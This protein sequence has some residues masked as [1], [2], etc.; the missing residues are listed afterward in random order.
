MKRIKMFATCTAAA[1]MITGCAAS[2]TQ[3]TVIDRIADADTEVSSENETGEDT[4]SYE[5]DEAIELSD[6]SGNVNITEGG[7]YL[8][9]GSSEDCSVRIDAGEDESVT[10]IL[11]GV[12][13]VSSSSAAI[14]AQSAGDV[15]IILADDCVLMNEEGFDDSEYEEIDA[16][17]CSETDMTISG[18]GELKITSGAGKGIAVNDSLVISGG[19]LDIDASDDGINVNEDFLMTGGSLTV[20]AGDDGIHADANLTVEDGNITINGAEGLEATYVLINGGKITITAADDGINAAQKNDETDVKVEINGGD[21]TIV[22]GEGDTDGIDSN[23]D[24]IINGGRIDITG[25]SACDYDGKA[26]LNG[27]TL[28]ING[29]ET[30]AIPNQFMGGGFG[31]EGVFGGGTVP[32][33]GHAPG[34]GFNG[35]EDFAPGNGQA[36]GEP[37]A[38][39][40]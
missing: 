6:D 2:Y 22:M 31:T 4:V 30:D 10:L 8:I 3:D 15:N 16:V 9:T 5:Y 40:R 36:P 18:D 37:P 7:I 12:K 17:I 32:E 14:Y 27:G 29:E 1:L 11:D 34:E 23:G 39:N 38:G 26:E 28:I 20:K 35:R 24:L 19:D 13:I 33:G 25:Q 21:I